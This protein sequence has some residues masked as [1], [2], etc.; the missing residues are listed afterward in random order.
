MAGNRSN[1]RAGPVKGDFIPPPG[2][3]ERDERT[4]EL[5]RQD[6]FWRP[7]ARFGSVPV[8]K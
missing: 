8:E 1:R 2:T 7:P 5:P 4:E 6:E 3:G